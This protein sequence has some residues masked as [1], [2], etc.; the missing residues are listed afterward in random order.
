M[1]TVDFLKNKCFHLNSLKHFDEFKF[2]KKKWELFYEEFPLLLNRKWEF[3]RELKW[4][5]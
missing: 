2:E 5:L 3:K 4:E 1:S